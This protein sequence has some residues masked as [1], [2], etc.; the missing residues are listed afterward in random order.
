MAIRSEASGTLTG[1][2]QPSATSAGRS[3]SSG[4]RS[5]T[6]TAAPRKRWNPNIQRVRAVVNG[7]AEARER[8]HELHQG[9]QGPAGR[10]G[11]APARPPTAAR[12]IRPP[13]P[14]HPGRASAAAAFSSTCAGEVA[15]TIAVVTS[16]RRSVHAIARRASGTPRPSAN[17]RSRSDDGEVLGR[18]EALATGAVPAPV[19]ARDPP[20]RRRALRYLPVSTPCAS[21]ENASTPSPSRAHA[22]R[23]SPSASRCEHRSTGVGPWPAGR[24]RRPRRHRPP[25]PSARPSTPRRP[26]AGSSPRRSTRRRRGTFPR[27]ASRG[28]SGGIDTGRSARSRDA[29]GSHRTASR[30]SGRGQAPVLRAGPHLPVDLRRDEDAVPWERRRARGRAS[31]RRD[32]AAYTFAVSN[33]FTPSWYARWMHARDAASSTQSPNVSHEPSEITE[34]FQPGAPEPAVPHRGGIPQSGST[35]PIPEPSG[36]ACRIAS[37]TNAL[38]EPDGLEERPRPARGAP[39]SRTRATQP[40]P[41]VFGVS[42]RSASIHVVASPSKSRSSAPVAPLEMPALDEHGAGA[43]RQDRAAPRPPSGRASPRRTPPGPPAS[44]RFGVTSVASGRIARGARRPRPRPGARDRAWRR[45][46]GRRRGWGSGSRATAS[47]TASTIAADASM[48]VFAASTP[49]SVDD[50]ADLIGHDLRRD[51]AS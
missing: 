10:L 14:P 50:G 48:P 2:W 49:M 27:A 47:A 11:A 13:A 18:E 46:P 16:G 33:R 8:L 28:R 5:P 51:T 31:P 37:V 20:G 36:S 26:T 22:G 6:P 15:P 7:V 9:R 39:R 24:A 44:G 19:A 29:A 3:R 1:P 43:H 30:T 17:G 32:R 38:P 40:V 45:R 25:P 21:G 42:M 34:T 35:G 12:S 4:W 41:W 23:T